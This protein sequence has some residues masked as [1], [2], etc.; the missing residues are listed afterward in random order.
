MFLVYI[1]CMTI[2]IMHDKL[3]IDFNTFTT[4]I[5]KNLEE[6]FMATI[7]FGV[8]VVLRKLSRERTYFLIWWNV[9]PKGYNKSGVFSFSVQADSIGKPINESKQKRFIAWF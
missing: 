6:W 2:F 5:E 4:K 1:A 9:K 8:L 3:E 7:F